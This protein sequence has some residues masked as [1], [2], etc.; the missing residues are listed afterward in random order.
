M[1][2]CCGAPGIFKGGFWAAPEAGNAS[3]NGDCV[4]GVITD[5]SR[6]PLCGGAQRAETSPSSWP[7]VLPARWAEMA[8]TWLPTAGRGAGADS[9]EAFGFSKYSAE[10]GGRVSPG[11]ERWGFAG[12]SSRRC[13]C[14]G[15]RSPGSSPSRE[16]LGIAV[17]SANAAAMAPLGA[18]W[19]GAAAGASGDSLT[20]DQ[21]TGAEF[22][23][24]YRQRGKSLLS[25]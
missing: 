22:P 25:E 19:R 15:D 12:L 16:Q 6:S 9:G 20:G 14:A 10:W 13:H 2:R 3:A 17:T 23:Y 5:L 11:H 7:G 24:S 18:A 4:G 1:A 8:Q 21:F